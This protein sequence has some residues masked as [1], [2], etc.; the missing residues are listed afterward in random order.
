MYEN[1]SPSLLNV[2]RALTVK[3]LYFPPNKNEQTEKETLDLDFETAV[4]EE[5]AAYDGENS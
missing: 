5:I 4:D 3:L 2:E 1:S